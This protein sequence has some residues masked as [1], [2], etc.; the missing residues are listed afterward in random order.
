MAT[1]SACGQLKGRWKV[2]FSDKNES[3]KERVRTVTLACMVLHNIC[4]ERGDSIARK[5]DLSVDP[6]TQEKRDRE[7]LGSFY[8]CPI[9]EVLK[10]PLL[11]Q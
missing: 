2:L 8:K 4:I 7:G 1:E 5:L 11:K 9:A 6:S 3:N 10:T